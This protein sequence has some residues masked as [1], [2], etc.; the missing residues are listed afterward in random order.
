MKF[1]NYR[2]KITR[3]RTV[4]DFM[5]I[6]IKAANKSNATKRAKKNFVPDTGSSKTETHITVS[7][8]KDITK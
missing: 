7:E 1:K 2:L 3:Q 4:T 5:T 8:C 6:D